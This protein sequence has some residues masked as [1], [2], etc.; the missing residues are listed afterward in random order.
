MHVSVLTVLVL[1]F[2]QSVHL[3]FLS[4]GDSSGELLQ[5][6]QSLWDCMCVVSVDCMGVGGLWCQCR[7]WSSLL[8]VVTWVRCN[9]GCSVRQLVTDAVGTS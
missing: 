3:H 8:G 1:P 7:P 9:I 2:K 5:A 4:L 6:G